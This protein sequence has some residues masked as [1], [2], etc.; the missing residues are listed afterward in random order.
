MGYVP[1]DYT[2]A[3]QYETSPD[4]QPRH[5]TTFAGDGAS[6]VA[7]NIQNE[8]ADTDPRIHEAVDTGHTGWHMPDGTH[9]NSA[10]MGY[11]PVGETM[12]QQQY[13][14]RVD[15]QPHHST[16]LSFVGGSSGVTAGMLASSASSLAANLAGAVDP[17][18]AA[19]HPVPA[20][21]PVVPR[22]RSTICRTGKCANCSVEDTSQWRYGSVT[23]GMLCSACGQYEQKHKRARPSELWGRRRRG[24]GWLPMPE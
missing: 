12:V 9:V 6:H 1:D 21:P 23:N 20:P 2:I 8:F 7:S 18:L 11:I 16:T 19:N 5:S 22:G 3:Q 24:R 10:P 14:M 15:D 4:D 17:A 13:Q